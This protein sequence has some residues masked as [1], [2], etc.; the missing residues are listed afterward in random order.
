MIIKLKNKDTLQAD[1]FYFKC[2]IGAKGISHK[3]F[4]GDL[5]TPKGL[6][7][8]NTVYFRSDRVKKPNTKL[9]IF[10][11]KNNMGWCND[12]KYPNKYN[13]IIKTNKKIR[14]EKMF[15][16]DKKYDFIIPI[17]YNFKNPKINK[18]SAIFIHL[19]NTYKPTAGCVALNFND[20]NILL[21]I[22]DKKNKIKIY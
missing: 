15:R 1:K 9:K 7:H 19:T 5:K 20:F 14:H 18:G 8:F 22:L 10:K 17:E 21:K 2:S 3:K 16:F 13:K 4:E 6:F 11:I 12:I